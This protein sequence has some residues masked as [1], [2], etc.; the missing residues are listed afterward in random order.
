MKD[1]LELGA[2]SERAAIQSVT[3]RTFL[4]R[5][6][7]GLGAA[8]L[9]LLEGRLAPAA[10]MVDNPLAARLPHFAP[11]A[12]RVIYLHMAG[13]PSQHELFDYKPALHRL[14]GKDCP[15]S[16]LKGKK[17]SEEGGWVG[18]R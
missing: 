7:L 18:Y 16:L 9:G 1:A 13:S 5:G 11:R 6:S 15:D 14:D 8:A 12:K 4:Q 3:R 2:R 10:T 17:E